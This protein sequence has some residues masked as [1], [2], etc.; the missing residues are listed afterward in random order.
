MKKQKANFSKEI[1]TIVNGVIRQ[2]S[3]KKTIRRI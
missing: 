2:L 3:T 1:E